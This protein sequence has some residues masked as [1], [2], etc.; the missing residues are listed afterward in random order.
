VRTELAG[1]EDAPPVPITF[2]EVVRSAPRD[3]ED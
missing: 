3:D 1:A 2:V